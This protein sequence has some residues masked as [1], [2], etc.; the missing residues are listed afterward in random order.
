MTR[1]CPDYSLPLIRRADRKPGNLSSITNGEIL[2]NRQHHI[3]LVCSCTLR[4]RTWNSLKSWDPSTSVFI[5]CN[6]GGLLPFQ[7][8][9]GLPV[10]SLGEL[11]L[12]EL[13]LFPCG[14]GHSVDLFNSLS[15]FFCSFSQL[16]NNYY[17]KFLGSCQELSQPDLR[18]MT[19]WIL[20]PIIGGGEDL[21]EGFHI[22]V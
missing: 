18:N 15:C 6:T 21:C 22:L 4:I 20:P 1:N 11:S 12:G 2:A 19:T 5:S 13:S 9:P 14:I 16:Q 10:Q 7:P 8:K 17:I 3:S